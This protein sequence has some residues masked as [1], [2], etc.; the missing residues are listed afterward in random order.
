MLRR[1]I[2]IYIKST[3]KNSNFFERAR[4]RRPE[5][6]SLQGV[7]EDSRTELIHRTYCMPV[8]QEQK[9][10]TP[11][12]R[13]K[14]IFRGALNLFW[15]IVAGV[16]MWAASLNLSAA[17]MNVL[18]KSLKLK[19]SEGFSL[20]SI[21]A[22]NIS[23]Q[24][25]TL[26]FWY[27]ADG[28]V[29]PP[30]SIGSNSVV[31]NIGPFSVG[32]WGYYLWNRTSR[33]GMPGI[34]LGGTACGNSGC[35]A[36]SVGGD[37]TTARRVDDGHWH[38]IA[39]TLDGNQL[40]L[41]V[42]G[43]LQGTNTIADPQSIRMAG[44]WYVGPP[45]LNTR[46]H[47]PNDASVD[48]MRLSNA[49]RYSSAAG[50]RATTRAFIPAQR[51]AS[52][53]AT[54]ALWHFDGDG[55]DASSNA[56]HF[57]PGG[58]NSNAVYA[59]DNSAARNRDLVTH[60]AVCSE[61]VYTPLSGSCV[62]E[63][64]SALKLTRPWYRV[65]Y[66]D[67]AAINTENSTLEYWLRADGG[68][69]TSFMSMMPVTLGPFQSYILGFNNPAYGGY[70][71]GHHCGVSAGAAGAGTPVGVGSTAAGPGVD[72]SIY[73]GAWHH[74][75]CVLKKTGPEE[76]TLRAY[77]DG[78][79]NFSSTMTM[80][81]ELFLNAWDSYPGINAY[82]NRNYSVLGAID[83]VRLSNVARYDGNFTPAR[84]FASDCDTAILWHF[85]GSGVDASGNGNNLYFPAT[86]NTPSPEGAYEAEVCEVTTSTGNGDVND[87]TQAVNSNGISIDYTLNA[88]DDGEYFVSVH[89]A[90]A[91]KNSAI[92][93]VNGIQATDFTFDSSGEWATIHLSLQSGTNML[94]L[95]GLGNGAPAKLPNVENLT[96][97]SLKPYV[98]DYHYDALARLTATEHAEGVVD[99]VQYD[100]AGNRD[101]VSSSTSLT[102]HPP[103]ANNDPPQ[104]FN[105]T[106]QYVLTYERTLLPLENDRDPDDDPLTIVSVSSPGIVGIENGGKSLYL[107]IPGP[108]KGAFEYTI[109]D[110]RGGESKA[111]FSYDYRF[112]PD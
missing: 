21:P 88:P 104:D 59:A 96:I 19:T 82:V 17:E 30:S 58:F 63:N 112:D 20:S 35:S 33:R 67:P 81:P 39:A 28:V 42:D 70:K 77:V 76:Y 69:Y 29:Y 45:G 22:G 72:V 12:S 65:S 98:V 49:V 2:N 52:D 27:R 95:Q 60:P 46:D 40:S 15:P 13:E 94:T 43:Y 68:W 86:N 25:S 99:E 24:Q 75:A 7:N 41:F 110:G 107:K 101:A 57:F 36:G 48:E 87:Y 66:A 106:R 61:E 23:L 111:I 50:P 51:L 97:S 62:G 105:S 16:T 14:C 1:K 37:F 32:I 71:Y 38:H 92:L 9:P 83:E 31:A 90:G 11:I 64:R 85:D 6:H 18:V 91:N 102:N 80:K 79:S 10:V 34:N 89:F 8:L 93:L 84:R 56:S 78:V 26:E 44:D 47:Y 100:P 108:G 109:S 4:K 3:S 54:V 5:N 53:A 103:I 55:L 73:D 74:V